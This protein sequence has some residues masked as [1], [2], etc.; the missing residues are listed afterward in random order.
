MK[1]EKEREMP[2]LFAIV[3]VH[4]VVEDEMVS[5]TTRSW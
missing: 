4:V 2:V 5:L 3:G 1:R